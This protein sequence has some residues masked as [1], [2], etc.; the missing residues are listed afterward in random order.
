MRGSVNWQIQQVFAL[1]NQIGQSKHAEKDGIRSELNTTGKAATWHNMGKNM[2][3]YSYNTADAYRDVW[4]SVLDH[5]KT[6]FGIKDV[7][8]LSG[9]HLRAF[10]DSKIEQGV[11]HAT[12]MQYAAACEKLETALNRYAEQMGTGLNYSFSGDIKN[13]RLEA[14]KELVKFE[15]SR[16][17]ASPGRLIEAIANDKHN[18]SAAMQH[19]GGAR[20]H[21]ISLV[22]A[23]Q[24]LGMRSDSVTGEV[25]GFVTIQGKGGKENEV[26]LSHG[27]YER[28]EGYVKASGEFRI[29]K[30]AYRADLKDA[31]QKT[32]QEYTGTHG[33]RWSFAQERFQEVQQHGL[34]YEQALAQVSKEMGHERSDITEHYLK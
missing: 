1:V 6:E 18:L 7:E 26:G 33:L 32:G 34:T 13:A 27:T 28:L 20:V 17:Y 21:E 24:L 14:H 2:G 31:A 15:G 4:R 19:D 10:L 29:D 22:K 3:I 11:A 12:F 8:R 16:A 30:D 25:K 5:T 9:E 23:N